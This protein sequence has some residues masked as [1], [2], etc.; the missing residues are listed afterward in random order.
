LVVLIF[1]FILF[2]GAIPAFGQ[3]ELAFEPNR[4]QA[5]S[6]VRF[7]TRGKHYGLF[8]TPD[9]AILRFTS[10]KAAVVRMK[11]PG[12]KPNPRIEG[13]EPLGGTTNYLIGSGTSGITEIPHYNKVRYDDVY[14]G[15]DVVYYGNQRHLEYDF[16][17]R[18]GSDPSQIRVAFE[19]THDM[20]IDANG[21]L[22]LKTDAEPL[23]QKKPRVYQE[24]DGREKG[25]DA[26]Y[27]I[28]GGPNG[29]VET[30]KAQSPTSFAVSGDDLVYRIK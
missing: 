30:A 15:I 18:P 5:D 2:F 8:L 16:V 13:M 24:I 11:F 21:D 17:V 26:A 1:V 29:T 23:I 19:G 14:S 27:V 12:Q 10:P 28:S 22:I 9:E 20:A 7:L 3:I 4:G 25:V 6:N